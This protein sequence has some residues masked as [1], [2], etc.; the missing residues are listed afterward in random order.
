MKRHSFTDHHDGELRLYTAVHKS[1]GEMGY[2]YYE[3]NIP[4]NERIR[5]KSTKQ[6]EFASTLSLLKLNIKNLKLAR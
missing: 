5:D 6:R 4:D 1:G 2:W 3:I